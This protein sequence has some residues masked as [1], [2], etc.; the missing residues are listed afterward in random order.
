MKISRLYLLFLILISACTTLSKNDDKVYYAIEINGVLCGYTE[1]S[2]TNIQKEGIEYLHQNMDMFIM[3]SLFGSEFNTRMKIISLINPVTKNCSLLKGEINQGTINRKFEVKIENGNAVISSALTGEPK[4]IKLQPDVL[5]G[6]EQVYSRLK[7]EFVENK[8]SEISFDILE[9]M[10][11]EIQN[12]TFK[13]LGKEKIELAGKSYETIIIEQQ[14]NKTG[15]KIK[16]W[17]APEL[18]YYAM[19]QVQ[20]RKVYLADRTVVDKIK[21]ASMDGSILSKTN[22]SISDVQAISYMK[23]KVK[24]EPTGV[25]LK[26]ED[27]NTPGQKFNGTI[28]DNIIEGIL[29]IQYK[30]YSGENAPQ[31]PANYSKN[32]ALQKYL[33]PS[34]RIESDNPELIN[35][36]LK[37]TKDADN[38]WEA[39]KLL[40]KWVAENI[41]YA[42]PGGGT[43]LGAY[44]MRAGEC[45]AH[46]MLLAA[47]C[48]AVGIPARVVFGG[49]YVPNKGGAFGQHAWNEIYMGDAGWIPVDATA[50]ETDFVDAG[51]I[52]ISD[53]LSAS[54]SFNAKSIEV[55]DYK[56][57]DKSPTENTAVNEMFNPYLGKY[58]NNESGKTFE[59]LVKEGNLAVDIPGQMVLPFNQKDENGR[60]YCKL[61]NR[62]Y[63]VFN[64]DEKNSINKMIFHEMISMPRQPDTIN[65]NKEVPE[66]FRP[67]IGN[68]LFAAINAVFK[69]EFSKNTLSVY[70]PTKKQ[71][72]K[73]Q[74]PDENG[75]WLDEFNKNTVRFE[76]DGNGNVT[77]LNVDAATKFDRQ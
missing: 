28:K 71:S 9:A 38:S 59:V 47:F 40:S 12:S 73:L 66:K 75:N 31:F 1:T 33:K 34:G 4:T 51:H 23:L 22:V 17:L 24:I 2:D 53:H 13:R 25:A 3:L 14:N 15:V 45:G 65:V 19:F 46:S 48:R 37:I 56:L 62:L 76:T 61:S 41:H 55:L 21:V 72:I 58:T 64:E 27:L 63:V 44:K 7:E 67:Y 42:I 8:T 36:A 32:A 6:S 10:D 49:M 18:D 54:S 77:A 70:D 11:S 52:R 35:E 16:Y 50:F 5:F 26:P 20:N 30:K 29:E 43:A 57:G 69:V 39:A 60:W 74:L 68:Y